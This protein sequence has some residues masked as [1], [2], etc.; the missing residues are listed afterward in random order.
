MDALA[1]RGLVAAAFF[2]GVFGAG[3]VIFTV[4]LA[5][6]PTPPPLMSATAVEPSQTPTIIAV[7]DVRGQA[8]E[9]AR[10][11]LTAIGLTV[12]VHGSGTVRSMQPRPGALVLEGTRVDLTAKPGK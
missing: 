1:R 8:V 4:T 12:E 7:P 5:P 9:E 10:Q 2:A 3:A 6:R 11:A